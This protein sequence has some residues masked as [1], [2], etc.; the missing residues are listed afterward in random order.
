MNLWQQIKV[1]FCK[2]DMEDVCTKTYKS[3]LF[4]DGTKDEGFVVTVQKCK[5]CEY[6]CDKEITE[7]FGQNRNN[8]HD[9]NRG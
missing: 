6:F 8:V 2:H 7:K 1:M 5:K 3:I 4:K 9:I